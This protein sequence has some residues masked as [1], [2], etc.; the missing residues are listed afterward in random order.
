MTL[1]RISKG[2]SCTAI[3]KDNGA[4]MSA[5]WMASIVLLWVVVLVMS[6]VLLGSLRSLALVR[7]RLQQLEA[8][9]PSRLGRRGLKR[10]AKAPDFVLP[11]VEGGELA[12]SGFAG[13]RI[14]LVFTQSGCAPCKRIVPELN[15]LHDQ[16]DVVVLVANH[17][18]PEL[19]ERW[20]FEVGAR[21]PVLVQE[22]L[23]LSRRY[24]VFATPFAFLVNE[25]GVI[26]AKG[27]V[28][29]REHLGFVLSGIPD[30]TDVGHAGNGE[31]VSTSRSRQASR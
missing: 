18:N 17:G 7:W 5:L 27:I 22:D 24:E 23:N 25:K 9:T 30:G 13:R 11:S 6:L 2:K 14:L 26:T 10:G 12:L 29:E 8:T 4:S 1:A 16:G 3:E 28:S 31:E 19:T 20:A 15:Q 21:F